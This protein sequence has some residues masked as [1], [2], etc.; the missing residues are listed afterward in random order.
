MLDRDTIVAQICHYDSAFV[1][2]G[3]S[4]DYLRGTL[5]ALEARADSRDPSAA[6]RRQ[7]AREK[8]AA[9]QVRT[10]ADLGVVRDARG[11][12][13]DE[14]SKTFRDENEPMLRAARLDR[15]RRAAR[16]AAALAAIRGGR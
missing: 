6:Y 2:D 3:K 1:D 9:D 7:L 10:D 14:G 12:G 8:A 11:V 4:V 16:E 13:I 5:E 15:E